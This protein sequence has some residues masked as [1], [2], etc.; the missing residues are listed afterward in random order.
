VN[1]DDVELVIFH[2]L[3]NLRAVEVADKPLNN[4]SLIQFSCNQHAI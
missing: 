2:H 3:L 1:S 4:L